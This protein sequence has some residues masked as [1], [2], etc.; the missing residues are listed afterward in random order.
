METS[1]VGQVLRVGL[2]LSLIFLVSYCMLSPL[3]GLLDFLVLHPHRITTVDF[4]AFPAF[5]NFVMS[6]Y[7]SSALD[8]AALMM[9]E[10]PKET[11]G[12]PSANTPPGAKSDDKL[13]VGY[14]IFFFFFFFRP[15]YTSTAPRGVGFLLRVDCVV[16]WL[17]SNPSVLVS[18]SFPRPVTSSAPRPS[19]YF[20]R[21]L[22]GLSTW[23]CIP[24]RRVYSH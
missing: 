21:Y 24:T 12:A 13:Q 20:P 14:I 18:F 23:D 15:R 4:I 5:E 9:G 2:E 22:R 10:N 17:I 1:L 11:Q 8:I 16:P 3:F 7:F 19:V 6:L